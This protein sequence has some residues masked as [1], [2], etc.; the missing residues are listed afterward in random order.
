MPQSHSHGLGAVLEGFPQ[1]FLCPFPGVGMGGAG[2][3]ELPKEATWQG[4]PWA[5][6][7]GDRWER[8]DDGMGEG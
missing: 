7:S 4:S 8:N 2:G 3:T 1:S 5:P 6:G